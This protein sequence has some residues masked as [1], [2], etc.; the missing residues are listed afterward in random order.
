MK[1]K[2]TL[3]NI[4]GFLS[5]HYR[6]A[7]D[8]LGFLESHIKEQALFRLWLVKQRS[9]KCFEEDSCVE[10]SCQISSKVFESRGCS[11]NI[12]YGEM[13]DQE[14]WEEYKT[15]HPIYKKYL[16]GDTNITQSC[17]PMIIFDMSKE[18]SLAELMQNNPT[19]TKEEL[20]YWCPGFKT[21]SAK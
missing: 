7:L 1:A 19:L 14:K 10:C 11:A 2:P 3:S 5:A 13:L 21:K 9:P 18:E 6:Q 12:C 17:S 4:K 20:L 15:V 16:K 8:E